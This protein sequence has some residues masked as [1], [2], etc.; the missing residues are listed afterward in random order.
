[1][2]VFRFSA[3]ES[4]SGYYRQI[5]Q[6]NSRPIIHCM[7]IPR[8]GNHRIL[9]GDQDKIA[10][11]NLY[12]ELNLILLNNCRALRCFELKLAENK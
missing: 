2:C 7:A 4:D 6:I 11:R 5:D 12:F 8:Y 1:M 10:V 3:E 9:E